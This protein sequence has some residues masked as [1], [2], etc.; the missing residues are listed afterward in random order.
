MRVIVA[1]H[2]VQIDRDN[3]HLLE[4]RGPNW[5]IWMG[6]S[7]I[8]YVV[9]RVTTNGVCRWQRLHR[10]VID[11]PTESFVDHINGNGLDN[12]RCNLR[13]CTQAENSANQRSTRT[14]SSKYRGVSR[15]RDGKRWVAQIKRLYKN[16][17]IGLFMSEKQAALAYNRVA[18]ELYGEFARLNIIQ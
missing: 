10:L 13:L 8:R 18:E 2:T 7:G 15:Y 16:K 5:F 14:G 12:R 9:R 6:Q 1:G 11:A 4:D 17:H 3:L